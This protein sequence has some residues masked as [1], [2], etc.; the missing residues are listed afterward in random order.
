M[1]YKI[2]GEGIKE[3]I[4]S[5][6]G[7]FII[8]IIFLQLW[9]PTA[10]GMLRDKL[11]DLLNE[12]NFVTTYGTGVRDGLVYILDFIVLLVFFALWGLVGN[13]VLKQIENGV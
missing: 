8:T 7:A 9:A 13:K 2:T 11:Y 10:G 3:V 12:S 1:G 6:V 5:I 4:M